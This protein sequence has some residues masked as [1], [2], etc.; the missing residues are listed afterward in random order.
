MVFNVEAATVLSLALLLKLSLL[1]SLSPLWLSMLKRYC[2]VAGIVVE[3]VIVAVIVSAM[4]FNVEAAV[5]AGIVVE[6]AVNVNVEA[7][8]VAMLLVLSSASM[9]LPFLLLLLM[10]GMAAASCPA[11]HDQAYGDR[12]YY[13]EVWLLLRR[14]RC[15]MQRADGACADEF[16]VRVRRRVRALPGARAGA[17]QVR[18]QE[19]AGRDQEDPR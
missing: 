4:V 15:A 10:S 17:G 5:V 2:I 6:I 12:K 13:E 8:V 14:M 18:H 19:G 16:R 1:L 11:G 9:H 7:A 3:V